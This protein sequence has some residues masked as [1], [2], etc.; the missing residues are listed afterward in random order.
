[1]N[2]TDRVALLRHGCEPT[3]QR[4][5]GIEAD[6]AADLLCPAT[7]VAEND[8]DA[9]VR[10]VLVSQHRETPCEICNTA[11]A[12]AVGYIPVIFF[13]GDRHRDDPPITLGQ[14]YVHGGF[15]WTQPAPG[16]LPLRAHP[17]RTDR[18]DHGGPDFLKHPG[19]SFRRRDLE[20]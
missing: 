19:V 16:S 17:T 20:R 14:S 9:L 12:L 10:V 1:M 5:G 2:L 18:L 3:E 6:S 11:D 15:S 4:S 8:C 13:K 7:R